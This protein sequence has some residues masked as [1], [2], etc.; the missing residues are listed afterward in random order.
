M[1]NSVLSFQQAILLFRPFQ[2]K[3]RNI[4]KRLVASRAAAIASEIIDRRCLSLPTD[5]DEPALSAGYYAFNAVLEGYRKSRQCIRTRSEFDYECEV[6]FLPC[7]R[8]TLLMLFSKQE[9]YDKEFAG[10]G[11]GVREYAYYNNTDPPEGFRE[12]KGYRRWERR[13]KDWNEALGSETPI[14]RG[15]TIQC[16]GELGL[17]IPM[18]PDMLAHMPTFRD[19][20]R[21]QANACLSEKFKE[22]QP[23][24]GEL[25]PLGWAGTRAKVMEWMETTE[26]KKEQRCQEEAI[27]TKLKQAITDEDLAAVPGPRGP[28]PPEAV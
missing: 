3:V 8:K 19:R 28:I 26:G 11:G 4:C 9:E 20:V 25:L 24:E 17:P 16:L 13:E 18:Y 7:R 12:G 14:V 23:E 2:E 15:F 1:V 6:T 21:R 10:I 22:M 5:A 27:R